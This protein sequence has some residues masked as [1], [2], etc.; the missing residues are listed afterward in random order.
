MLRVEALHRRGEVLLG[1]VA[2]A[3]GGHGRVHRRVHQRDD[4][5]VEPGHRDGRD[6]AVGVGVE[7]ADRRVHADEV[8]EPLVGEADDAAVLVGGGVLAAGA[9]PP[10]DAERRRDAR[11]ARR[12]V[13]VAAAQRQRGHLVGHRAD[14]GRGVAGRRP[15]H[16]GG[17]VA[18]ER[19][20]E[21]GEV[22]LVRAVRRVGAAGA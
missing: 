9:V 7:L 19:R 15:R 21:D 10:R 12:G 18:R 11:A 13:R 20:R 4:G 6:V 17:R 2:A 22:R 14:G 8:E 16:R 3:A 1:V 5:G